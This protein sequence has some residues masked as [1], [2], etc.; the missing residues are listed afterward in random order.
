MMFSLTV[1]M[2]FMS[3][4]LAGVRT[5]IV[6]AGRPHTADYTTRAITCIR[7]KTLNIFSEIAA[8]FDHSPTNDNTTQAVPS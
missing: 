3:V 4:A 2:K 6:I 7:L 8:V 5:P 1:G